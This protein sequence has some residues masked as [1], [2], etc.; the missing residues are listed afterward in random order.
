V[1]GRIEVIAAFKRERTR[2]DVEK[3]LKLDDVASI[4]WKVDGSLTVALWA[5]DAAESTRRLEQALMEEPF[6]QHSLARRD[7]PF[8]SSLDCIIVDAL[9]DDPVIPFAVLVG[10]TGLSPKTVRKHLASLLESRTVII[11]PRV[12]VKTGSGDLVYQL[13]VEGRIKMNAIRGVL[14][15][16]I[17]LHELHE[18]PSRFLLCRSP[19]LGEVTVKTQELGRLHGVDSVRLSL[20]REHLFSSSLLH[21]L[22]RQRLLELGNLDPT[23][24]SLEPSVVGWNHKP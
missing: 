13:V 4:G 5:G 1:F 11:M 14:R 19:D 15:D 12:G 20:N 16:S 24:V 8:L 7:L 3:L 9:A 23:S 22:A 2:N 21:R 6:D 18:P 10:K 17:L